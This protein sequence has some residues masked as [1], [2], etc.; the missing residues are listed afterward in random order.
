MKD[1]LELNPSEVCQ[2]IF[3]HFDTR[4]GSV[5]VSVWCLRKSEADC[6]SGFKVNPARCES[7]ITKR[8]RS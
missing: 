4:A 5:F 2:M 1:D 6:S 7:K 8:L 3:T